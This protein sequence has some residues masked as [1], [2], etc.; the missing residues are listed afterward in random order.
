MLLQGA[1]GR[2][3]PVR[4]TF[5]AFKLNKSAFA[6]SRERML[7]V[8]LYGALTAH[9][10]VVLTHRVL[11]LAMLPYALLLVAREASAHDATVVR[12]SFH[13]K[14]VVAQRLGTFAELDQFALERCILAR[15]TKACFSHFFPAFF[16]LRHCSR[17]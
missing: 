17:L 14:R 11:L 10:V 9:V 1:L 7:S 13:R 6:F 12:A 8:N 4:A 3:R 2:C 15:H 5:L 16:F